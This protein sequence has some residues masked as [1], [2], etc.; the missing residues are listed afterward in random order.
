MRNQKINALLG[1]FVLAICFA[2]LITVGWFLQTPNAFKKISALRMG[3]EYLGTDGVLLQTKRNNC[4]P[5]AL[6][7]IFDYYN[8]P[9]S[10]DEIE[11][12]VGL[13]EKGTSMLALKK[14]AELKGLNAE[15]WRLTLEDFLTKQFPMLLFV[16][17]DHY[18]V[19]DSVR[20]GE[21][22]IRDPA[23]GRLRMNKKTLPSI[24]NGETLIFKKK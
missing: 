18:I 16:H 17:N 11:T 3:A 13:T 24:W 20:N 2:G 5:T 12:N 9:T 15:G 22:F 4:G 19:A 23:L 1:L 6:K 10:L 8:I 14:M 7:M 21:I